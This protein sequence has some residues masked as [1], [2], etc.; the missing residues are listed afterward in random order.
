MRA[1]HSGIATRAT[2][3]AALVG[4]LSARRNE[5]VGDRRDIGEAPVFMANGRKAEVRKPRRT[6]FAQLAQP[7]RCEAAARL[8]EAAVLGEI[9]LVPFCNLRHLD[10][11]LAPAA[12]SQP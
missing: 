3:S 5:R 8:D 6:A 4:A 10:Y 9:R 7:R 11:D 1:A 2:H 12:S